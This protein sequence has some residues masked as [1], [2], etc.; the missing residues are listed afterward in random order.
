MQNGPAT[1]RVRSRTR[2]PLRGPAS[3]CWSKFTA[4]D[5]TPAADEDQSGKNIFG[6]ADAT[7]LAGDSVCRARNF[8]V[9]W[10][11]EGVPSLTVGASPG[12]RA[13]GAVEAPGP[14]YGRS[15]AVEVPGQVP[16][17]RAL[18]DTAAVVLSEGVRT[19][20]RSV[21]VRSRSIRSVHSM[22]SIRSV[23]SIRFMRSIRSI[24]YIRS[25]RRVCSIRSIRFV[26]LP[27]GVAVFCPRSR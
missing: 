6:C 18:G 4:I 8:L 13:L 16:S 19:R 14:V 22:R 11:D 21:P 9:W 23:R 25:V 3:W 26:R 1:A 27:Q 12:G 5:A 2:R 10:V 20:A 24:R 15:G 17:C 7:P